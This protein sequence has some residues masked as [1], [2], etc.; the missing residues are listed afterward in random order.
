MFTRK[1]TIKVLVG[2][3]QIGQQNKIV[4]QSMT[5]IKTS[6][7]KVVIRQINDLTTNGAELVRV[8][9]LDKDD[10]MALKHIIQ[11]APCPIIADVHYNSNFAIAAIKSGAAKIRI[12]PSNISHDRLKEIVDCAKK[13]NTAIRIGFNQ[14]SKSNN[15]KNPDD[16]VN[17]AIQLIKQF[18]K[19]H[20]YK[21]IVSLKSS[22]S[23]LVT[24]LY[25][26]AAHKIKYPLHIG[27]TEAGTHDTAIIKSVLGLSPLLNKGI[28][29]T[30][31]I[32]ITGNPLVEPVVT[33]KILHALNLYPNLPNV[34]SCPTCGRLQWDLLSLTN[35]VEKYI[36]TINKPITIAI[37]GCA[38]NG[39]GECEHADIGV[40]GSQNKLFVY[41]KGKHIKTIPIRNG[42]SEIKKLIK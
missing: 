19:W 5:N 26:L 24:R 21:I 38:V 31:R 35:Q 8:S 7:W 32:S 18:E 39:I 16:M 1:N 14:G 25:E 42:F 17:S 3:I 11:Y 10:V 15:Y 40:Y 30:M 20:F 27:V 41:A 13:Y 6:N 12:N 36:A 37:M 2:N 29:D 28:G 23:S 33:K 34:I 4:I 9:L 22:D